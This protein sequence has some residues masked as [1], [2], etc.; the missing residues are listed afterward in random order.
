MLAGRLKE[1]SP[2]RHSDTPWLD[3]SGTRPLSARAKV[4][5]IG[6]GI[7]GASLAFAL[8]AKG[9]RPT[10]FDPGG[11]GAGASGNP[12]G[13]IMPRIDLGQNA[14]SQFFAHAYVHSIAR[15][16]NLSAAG[17]R[18]L[19]NQCGVLQKFKTKEEIARAKRILAERLLPDG[20][21]EE[22]EDGLFFPQ[23]GVV[24]PGAYCTAL[25]GDTDLIS[26]RVSRIYNLTDRVEIHAS[27]GLVRSFDG[28]IVANSVAALSFIQC[29]T[30]PL[31][32]VKGQIDLFRGVAP[33]EHV[34]I[35]G[36]YA[37]PA[38]GG[39]T[40]IG[41]TYDHSGTQYPDATSVEATRENICAV[42]ALIDITP[43]EV[44]GSAPRAAVRCQTPD[45]LPIAGPI[46]DWDYFSACYD[47]VRTGARGPFPPAQRI[48]NIFILGGLG[49]RGLVTA[50]YCADI[51]A[52][53]MTG[54]PAPAE[55]MIA[56]ALDPA[57]FFI[58]EMKRTRTIRAQ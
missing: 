10:L 1:K 23:G 37:A 28:V 52:A 7:A 35:C 30:L 3:R 46:P 45:F 27:T 17:N 9:L 26:E 49:S 19:F 34:I 20:W 42:G 36:S 24:D 50:P 38:P 8:R 2:P 53:A 39:G 32:P 5:V 51:I 22:H 41:A 6:G 18:N 58:R 16:R 21:V 29:R 13:L 47:G 15:L 57:R 54:G 14:D 4:A 56:D 12:A 33:P 31:A 44:S 48:T 55:R 11:V 43:L 40:I 25:I